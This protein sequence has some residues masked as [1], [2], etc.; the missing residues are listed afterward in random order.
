MVANGP[1]GHCSDNGEYTRINRQK[2]EA[3]PQSLE[4][5]RVVVHLALR[6]DLAVRADLAEGIE[7]QQKEN[8]GILELLA[9]K[10]RACTR[11]SQDEYAKQDF[12][13]EYIPRLA[14]M[15]CT[16]H[17]PRNAEEP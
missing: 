3:H 16:L 8:G 2:V 11:L 17:L 10:G 15:G 6:A 5:V 4:D 9:E 13:V 7:R 14:K 1:R 12:I